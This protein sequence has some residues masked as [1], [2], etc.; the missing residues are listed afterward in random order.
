LSTQAY[1]TQQLPIQPVEKPILCNPYAEPTAHWVYDTATG[2][3]EKVPGRRKAFYWYKSRRVMMAQLRL[4]FE[5][6][7]ESEELPLVNALR[8]DVKRWRA[9]GYEGATEITKELL[10]YW[11]REDRSLRLFFCQLEAAETLIFLNEIRLGGKYLRF[12]P[13]FTDENLAQLQDPPLNLPP[14]GGTKGGTLTRL[15]LKMAT[16]SGKTVVMAMLIAW[17]FCN[18]AKVPSDTRFPEAALVVCPNLTIKERLQVLRPAS[19]GNYYEEFDL[20]PTRLRPLLAQGKVLITNWHLFLPESEHAEGGQTYIVVNKGP[21][22]PQAFARRVLGDLYDRAP[23]IVF[24]DEAHHAW[25][26]QPEES[27][28]AQKAELETATVWVK[29][30]DKL[31]QAVGIRCCVDL[32]ATPFYIQG[33]GYVEGS[34]FPWLVSDFGLVD[35]IESGLVKIPRLPVSDTTGRPDPKYFRLWQ[36]ITEE[37]LQPGD[38]LSSGR[39]RRPKP[40]AVYREAEA[41]LQ[42]LA[43]QW[44]ERFQY[45]EKATDAQDK[46]PPVLIVVCDN[47]DLAAVFFRKLSGESEIEVE[48]PGRGKRTKTVTQTVYGKGEVFPE[49]FSNTETLKPTVRIDTQLLDQAESADPTVSRQEA[50]EQLRRI[51]ATVGQP[52]EPGE[53][54]R[55]VV[56]VSML[57]EGWDAHNVTHILG[58]RAFGSQLLCEQVVGRGLRRM[59]Y[60]VDKDSG[61]L[62]EEYVDIYGVPFSLI[63]FKGRP[64]QGKAPEDKPKN[65]VRALPERAQFEIKFPVVEGYAFAL[66]RNVITAEVDAIERLVIAPEHEPTAVFVKPRV[67]YEIGHPSLAGP[68]EFQMQDR[69]AYY[70]STHVQTIAFEITRQIVTVLGGAEFQNPAL[71]GDPQLRGQSRH[72]LFP[73]VLRLV[74]AYIQQRVDCRDVDPCELGQERYTQLIVERLLAAIK[75]DDGA[76]EAPLLPILNRYQPTGSTAEVDFKTTRPCFVTTFSHI[77]LVAADTARWEQSAAFRLEAAVQKGLAQCYARNDELG[78]LIPYDFLGTSQHYQPDFL[79]R[80]ADGTTLVLEIKGQ[81]TEQDRAKHAAAKRWIAAVNNWGHLGRWA[82]QVCQDPQMLERELSQSGRE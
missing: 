16:G 48:I 14:A 51:V 25:R 60:T 66:K 22:G 27:G 59:D 15:G 26:P 11:G 43:G 7:E 82:F 20:V 28:K 17:A 36:H 45:I 32:S 69:Q 52:G 35:A 46:T 68:G 44:A 58:V 40:E 81:E 50:A 64:T 73:Q 67:G 39:A 53:Q 1:S 24:N 33:S 71:K 56:A 54:V 13:T 18:R 5:A 70:A 78:V 76:G 49:Y 3:A 37:N 61:L 9:G 19:A 21:E 74:H 34:P 79:A 47:I 4:G 63:P 41:A 80:L 42:T 2:L 72:Q 31:N 57:N 55:C 77:N 62:T 10:R 12:K 23:L 38:Y 75:P 65:H 29:G 8:E 6:E 30:L